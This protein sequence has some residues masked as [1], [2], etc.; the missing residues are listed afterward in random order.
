MVV[1]LTGVTAYLVLTKLQDQTFQ[2]LLGGALALAV[3][4][5]VILLMIGYGATQ[6]YI[7]RRLIAQDDVADMKLL[8]M[9][10]AMTRGGRSDVRLISPERAG[11]EP[12]AGGLLAAGMAGAYR[13][14][15]GGPRQDDVEI[16]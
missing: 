3:V 13:D 2:I 12:A 5:I 10:N 14:I 16:E 6:A 7:Q 11:T 8:A 4:V 1:M 9:V 15:T